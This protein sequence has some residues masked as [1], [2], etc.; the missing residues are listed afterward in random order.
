MLFT[1]LNLFQIFFFFRECG[2]TF[3]S[4]EGLALHLR[5]HFGDHSFLSD[6]C[7]LAASLKQSA[8]NAALSLSLA[9]KKTHICSDCGRGF[10]QKHGLFTHKQRH[11]N[12]SCKLKPFACEKCGKC[13]AQKNHLSLHERQHMDLPNQRNAS[14]DPILQQNH[15]NQIIKEDPLEQSSPERNDQEDDLSQESENRL[16]EQNQSIHMVL[17]NERNNSIM[18]TQNQT[19]RN[20]IHNSRLDRNEE[21]RH[22]EQCRAESLNHSEDGLVD[23]RHESLIGMDLP[24]QQGSS[25]DSLTQETEMEHGQHDSLTNQPVERYLDQHRHTN[26]DGQHSVSLIRHQHSNERLHSCESLNSTTR[27]LG[28]QRRPIPLSLIYTPMDHRL[29]ISLPRPSNHSDHNMER[30]DM[31]SHHHHMNPSPP[32]ETLPASTSSFQHASASKHQY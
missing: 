27:S 29:S 7:S 28:E 16:A 5:L 1:F 30:Q 10:T 25:N 32:L 2:E 12:G 15:T 4:V 23:Q 3:A 26:N 21:E 20:Q 31:L 18:Q 13:F 24:S 8:V 9:S 19:E 6:I 14:N 22:I 11:E 17:N